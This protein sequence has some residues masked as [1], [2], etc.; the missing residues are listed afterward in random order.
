MNSK[1]WK[2]RKIENLN[3]FDHI[4]LYELVIYQKLSES[5]KKWKSLIWKTFFGFG[6]VLGPKSWFPGTKIPRCMD[7][8]GKP[9]T[10]N[11]SN[12][13]L[14]E[15]IL[16]IFYFLVSY[17]SVLSII[18]VLGIIRNDHDHYPPPPTSRFFENPLDQPYLEDT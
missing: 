17:S 15:P 10:S 9:P 6:T 2:N 12:F 1:S 11:V 4:K 8:S 14:P 16:I 13:F 18:N 5:V 3:N 7:F